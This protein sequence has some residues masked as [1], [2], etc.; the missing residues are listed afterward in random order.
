MRFLSKRFATTVTAA[1]LACCLAFGLSA[2]GSNEA[3]AIRSATE[4][5]LGTPTTMSSEKLKG[6]F[7]ESGSSVLESF[8]ELSPDASEFANHMFANYKYNIGDIKVNGN[9]ATVDVSIT[10]VDIEKVFQKVFDDI[11]ND[12]EWLKSVLHATSVSNQDEAIAKVTKAL[13][14]KFFQTMDNSKDLTTTNVTAH[15]TKTI[16][17][18]T[19]DANDQEA[20]LAAML[21]GTD[22]KSIEQDLMTMSLDAGTTVA[23]N[24]L[25][26]LDDETLN[27]LL[28]GTA[29]AGI[30]RMQQ[31]GVN[32]NDLFKHVF[33]RMECQT[34]DATFVN[35]NEAL[36]NTT[37]SNVDLSKAME[38]A[39]NSLQAD[40]EVSGRAA[41]LVAANDEDGIY[42]LFVEQI[43]KKID[44][45]EDRVT[46]NV[47]I[48]FQRDESGKWTIDDTSQEQL[49][50]GM[51]GGYNVPAAS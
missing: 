10:N 11:A 23:F 46:S 25:A 31:A 51:L 28:G 22:L 47:Q 7:G 29:N 35:E 16:N 8:N 34:N 17:E 41:G 24:T 43:I 3:D 6:Q 14:D 2:C 50:L 19:I 4:N 39:Q 42:R 27:I 12:R 48:K 9:T 1:I 15:L 40:P 38:S 33:A 18:W 49:A 37:I 20:L 26:N 21:G 13:V 44:E 5:A 30:Q 36:V 45:T 32:V